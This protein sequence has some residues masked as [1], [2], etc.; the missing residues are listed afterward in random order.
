MG[1]R[2]SSS[3]K[4]GSGASAIKGLTDTPISKLQ[5]VVSKSKT[6]DVIKAYDQLSQ[7]ETVQMTNEEKMVRAVVVDELL[8]RGN[9]LYD[10]KTGDYKKHQNANEIVFYN[11]K[12]YKIKGVEKVESQTGEM[13]EFAEA[14]FYY[15]GKFSP[16]KN[17][18]IRK[19]LAKEYTKKRQQIRR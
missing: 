5:R 10:P 4:A 1:G 12:S 7:K 17:Y 14:E 13:V 15:N 9:L 18:P 2:G 11:G 19:S 16:V 6:S 8:S 3:G